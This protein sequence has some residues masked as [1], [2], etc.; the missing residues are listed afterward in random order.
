MHTRIKGLRQASGGEELPAKLE[1]LSW[2]LGGNMV[3][4]G[5]SHYLFSDL[6][7]GAVAALMPIYTQKSMMMIVMID[8]WI[9]G[10]ID[11]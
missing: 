1:N 4:D 5:V 3:G 9:D 7:N 2:I 10:W 11:R 6:Y 8:R